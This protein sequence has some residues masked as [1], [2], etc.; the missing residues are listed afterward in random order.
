MTALTAFALASPLLLSHPAAGAPSNPPPTPPPDR[1]TRSTTTDPPDTR[2]PLD[3]ASVTHRIAVRRG[4]YV[5]VSYAIRTY[6]RIRTAE[7]D[8]RRRN[9]VIELGTD[10]EPGATRNIT[11]Y[12]RHGRLR[13]DLISNATRE[14]IARL[15]IRRTG[16]RSLRI[17]GPRSLSGA[18]R[19]FVVSRFEDPETAP[20]GTA[21][22]EPVTCGDQVPHR[23]WLRMDRPA[24]P[25]SSGSTT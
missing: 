3:I 18:R 6:D 21:G 20:C 13:A 7:L 25:R 9:F 15:A 8:R 24:W 1:V 11:V 12:A 4:A 22:G 16:A 19:Y 2:G 14:R 17:A 5:R 10:G 23:G